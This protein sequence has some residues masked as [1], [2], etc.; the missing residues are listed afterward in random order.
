MKVAIEGCCHG[1]LDNIYKSIENK[2]VELLIICGDFQSVRNDADLQSMSVPEK[3]KMMGDFQDYYMGKKKAPVFTIFIGGNHESSSYLEELKYGGFVAPRIYYMGRSSVVWYKGLRIGGLSGVYHKNNFMK[4]SQEKYSFPLNPSSL[5]SIYHYRKDDYFKLKLLGEAN[6]MIMLTHDWPEGIY[7]YGDVRQLLKL[8]PFFK[9]DIQKRDLGSPFT[10]SLLS[11][12]RPNYWFSAHLHTKFSAFVD[13][14][15]GTAVPK[16]RRDV[17]LET[18]A[19]IAK[20]V[21][22]DDVKP[23][24]ETDLKTSSNPTVEVRS[25]KTEKLSNKM[26]D[27]EIL[28]DMDDEEENQINEDEIILEVKDDYTEKKKEKRQEP[29]LLKPTHFL[30]LDKCLPRRK[31]MEVIDIPLSDINH[32]SNKD[33]M[34]PFYYDTEYISSFKVIESCK[35]KLNMLTVEEILYPPLNLYEEL[36][37]AKKNY[38]RSF[39]LMSNE[40]YDRMFNIGMNSFVQTA[41]PNEKHYKEYRNPQTEK[42]KINFLPH[43]ST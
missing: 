16:K 35:E 34:K 27:G 11:T 23:S 30:A 2:E 29:K 14:N 18:K 22:F 17:D 38:L 40:E 9:Q 24:C 3:Y 21:K 42:F 10:I 25:T 7:N 5:R 37:Y 28:L 31:Y 12:L 20:R 26:D 8:K 4:L 41:K 33:E 13:W 43:D 36:I 39:E 19:D 6:N 32:A 1:C 15:V